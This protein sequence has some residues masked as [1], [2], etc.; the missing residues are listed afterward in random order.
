MLV[1]RCEGFLT[2]EKDLAKTTARLQAFAEAGAD[3]LYAPGVSTDEEVATLVKAI[4][5]LPLNVLV[6]SLAMTQP[7]LASLGVRRIS[8]GGSLA[9]TAWGGFIKA[10]K[11]IAEHGSFN[12]FA[13]AASG[14][15]LNKLF[16]GK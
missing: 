16:A 7:H 3:C 8:V 1:A 10:A 12:A 4:S 13:D 2:G 15:A 5:P 14:G 9:R 6:M 11:E